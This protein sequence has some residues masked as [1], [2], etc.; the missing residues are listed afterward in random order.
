MKK[1]GFM[2]ARGLLI[3]LILALVL[4]FF[5]MLAKSSSK[6]PLATQVE[7]YSK[8]QTEVTRSTL[9]NLEKVVFSYIS[10]QGRA[11]ESLL[12]IQNSG[13]L[14]GAVVDGWGRRIKYEKLSDSTFRLSSAGKDRTF[15]TKDD[16]VVED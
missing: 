1:G 14:S 10:D 5:L 13:H 6:A 2:P 12:E 15:G 4:V 11:P 8:A 3:V 7:V 16:I 9:Q